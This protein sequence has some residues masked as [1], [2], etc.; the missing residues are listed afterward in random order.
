MVNREPN[1]PAGTAGAPAA[2]STTVQAGREALTAYVSAI[3]SLAAA[4]ERVQGTSDAQNI[5][6]QL[7]GLVNGANQRAEAVKQLPQADQQTLLNER[8]DDMSRAERRLRAQ[9]DRIAA[10]ESLRSLLGADLDRLRL[11]ES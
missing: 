8:R 3:D 9:R 1:Q 4:L 2:G 6:S 5:K 7:D 10:N 11:I